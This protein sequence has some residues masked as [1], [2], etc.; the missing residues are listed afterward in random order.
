[1]FQGFPIAALYSRKDLLPDFEDRVHN[2][3]MHDIAGNMVAL[4][5]LLA[6]VLSAFTSVTW[7]VVNEGEEAATESTEEEMA[8]AA[9]A[10]FLALNSGS[11]KKRTFQQ[12]GS[13]ARRRLK[14]LRAFDAASGPAGEDSFQE[15]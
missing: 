4:P 11:Q 15:F 12:V 2:S 9:S 8:E 10:A 6:L 3:C 5:I 14:I 7:R 1:M 13:G